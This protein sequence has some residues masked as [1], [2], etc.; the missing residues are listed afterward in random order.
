M[1][2]RAVGHLINRGTPL[3]GAAAGGAIGAMIGPEFGVLGGALGGVGGW[4]AQ[5]VA[6]RISERAASTPRLSTRLFGAIPTDTTHFVGRVA[7]LQTLS[8]FVGTHTTGVSMLHGFG[9]CGKSALLK[10]FITTEGTPKRKGVLGGHP[11]VFLWSFAH[12]P[13]LSR[14]FSELQTF[15]DE[16][17]DRTRSTTHRDATRT[18]LSIPDQ[19]AALKHPIF[20][21]LDGIEAVAIEDL[22][23]ASR[24]GSVAV[25]ALRALLQ[26]TAEEGCGRLHVLCT[27]RI[28]PPEL[29]GLQS[30]LLLSLD[31]T[32]MGTEDGVSLMRR[33]AIRGRSDRVTRLVRKLRNH[34]YSIS[35]MSDLLRTAYRGDVR[36]ADA[37]LGS[38]AAMDAPLKSI[39]NW[40]QGRLDEYSQTFLQAVS[41]FRTH[42]GL[43]EIAAL[44]PH[45][46]TE[47]SS[48]KTKLEPALPLVAAELRS[49]GLLYENLD[50][51]S[52]V[53]VFAMHPL[54]REYFYTQI[55]SPATFHLE[56]AR[57]IEGSVPEN[58]DISNLE[59]LTLMREL[60]YQAL[61]AGD[62][63]LAWRVYRE[64]LGGYP[65]IGY[66]LADHPLGTSIIEMFLEH[67]DALIEILPTPAIY[68][69]FVDGALYLKNEGRLDDGI[70]TLERLITLSRRL[71]RDDDRLASALLVKAGIEMLRGHISASGA[72]IRS[73]DDIFKASDAH[74]EHQASTR[75]ARELV[76]RQAT[77]DVVRGRDAA[78][79]FERAAL[80]SIEPGTIPHDYGPIRHAWALMLQGKHSEADS[81]IRES[82]PPLKELGAR[83][84]IQ[85]LNAV[86]ALNAAWALDVGAMRGWG[87]RVSEWALKADIHVELLTRQQQ[88]VF[89]FRSGNLEQAEIQLTRGASLAGECGFLIEWLDMTAL[90]A[91]LAFAKGNRGRALE[92]AMAVIHGDDSNY[93]VELTGAG[94]TSVGYAWALIPA[95]MIARASN[96]ERSEFVESTLMGSPNTHFVESSNNPL[97]VATRALCDAS[98][99][100]ASRNV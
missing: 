25:P 82:I 61:G 46:V 34:A 83:M 68:D 38:G 80:M 23:S 11:A 56:A 12:D 33:K 72:S 47:Y 64:R 66:E 74:I 27:S 53:L 69:L 6:D 36:K 15:V 3:L 59:Q 75:I 40:Y 71:G 73:A 91:H 19:I 84:L 42:V 43:R 18:P 21:I 39:L 100:N 9:G 51:E 5:A 79:E 58:P 24:N 76:T 55:T 16:L 90:L 29:V 22:R 57:I 65:R 37:V 96:D 97:I 95:L 26:R 49:S 17:S 99:P 45:L 13:D 63:E 54:I 94:A 86:G 28:V 35:L 30:G 20:L 60:I 77:L 8:E 78:G 88:G 67:V 41:L 1:V 87:G 81:L 32:E 4:L 2:R 92:L 93:V 70:T 85:R 89:E 10:Q 14:F 98:T 62:V 48:R 50:R 31:L 44:I 52:G 7:E